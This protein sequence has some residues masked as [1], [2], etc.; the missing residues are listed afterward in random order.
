[1]LYVLRSMGILDLIGNTPI[2]EVKGL[3]TGLC[4]LFVKMESMNPTGSIKDRPALAMIEDAEERGV[5]Q[6][7]GC[8]VEATAGNTGLGLALVAGQKG[9]KTVFVVPDKFSRE[10]VNYMRALGAQVV[11]TRSDVEKG[12]PDYYID[13]ARAIARE[14]PGGWHVDQF[15][16][17]SNPA[18]H[19]KTTGPEIWKQMDGDVDAIV[20]GVGSGGTLGGLTRYFS[21]VAPHLEMVLGDPEGSVLAPFV[22]TGRIPSSVGSWLVEGIGEDF[23]PANAD[24]ST[25]KAAYAISD[26]E[27]FTTARELNK[28]DGIMGGPSSGVCVAAAIRYCREQTTPKKVLTFICDAGSKYLSKMY[29]DF[30]MIEQG[31]LP[32]EHLGDLRDLISHPYWKN[33][34]VSIAPSDKLKSAYA[35]MKTYDVSQLPVLDGPKLV[36]VVDE[37]DL[38]LALQDAPNALRRPVSDVMTTRLKIVKPS[39]PFDKVVQLLKKGLVAIVADERNFYGVITKMDVIEHLR[40]THD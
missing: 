16:N 32:K 33:A 22:T 9:Y 2:L 4:R 6:P 11:M 15:S 20:V 8:V 14:T 10:K 21:R 39:E 34:V 36:G 12:H 24:L 30:W 29:N 26:R 37:S 17:P 25:V 31:F 13:R 19:E 1:M 7:G 3:D 35:R 23:I 27:A 28:S 38:V 5:I 40:R 18:S